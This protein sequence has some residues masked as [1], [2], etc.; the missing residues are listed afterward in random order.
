MPTD[1]SRSR[2]GENQR[3]DQTSTRRDSSSSKSGHIRDFA[4]LPFQRQDAEQQREGKAP[5]EGKDHSRVDE[6]DNPVEKLKLPGK[7]GLKGGMPSSEESSSSNTDQEESSS[8]ANQEEEPKSPRTKYFED[9]SF[10]HE[11]VGEALDFVI[12]RKRDYSKYSRHKLMED[13]GH[14]ISHLITEK[15]HINVLNIL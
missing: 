8:D 2:D 13:I 15:Q 5:A 14:C 7:S 4:T 12:A 6:D 1:V 10:T 3:S 9:N 11:D